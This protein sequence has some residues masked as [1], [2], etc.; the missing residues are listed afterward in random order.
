[1]DALNSS[2][3]KSLSLSSCDKLSD[4][5]AETFFPRLDSPHLVNLH[6][7][8]TGL[9]RAAVPHL[10][11]YLS[12]PRARHLA[13]LKLS[14][15][16]LTGRGVARIVRSMHQANFNLTSME[17]YGI[18]TLQGGREDSGE[19]SSGDGYVTL[20]GET[21]RFGVAMRWVLS[22]NE[23]LQNETRA[24]ALQLLRYSRAL[25]IKPGRT[26]EDKARRSPFHIQSLPTELQLQILSLTVDTLSTSQRMRIFRFASD[27]TT[28]PPLLPELLRRESEEVPEL[29]LLEKS[30]APVTLSPRDANR[31]QWLQTVGCDIYEP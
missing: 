2:S 13:G 31:A 8:K 5:F 21:T 4:T 26:N 20:H 17:M 6:L 16:N 14:A 11:E 30:S 12:S 19:G 24:A 7:S 22:R 3:L 29:D 25:L 28:L 23:L 27:S 1:M 18:R 15:N 10:V 9:T